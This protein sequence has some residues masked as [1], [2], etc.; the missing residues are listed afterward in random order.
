MKQDRFSFATRSLVLYALVAAFIC[1]TT[2][3]LR[4]QRGQPDLTVREHQMSELER[5][6]TRKREPTEL[7]A[8]VNEDMG[9]LKTLNQKI[10]AQ[11][12]ATDQELNYRSIVDNLAEINTRAKRLG[13]DLALPQAEKDE[14]R[15]VG[16][17]VGNGALQPALLELNKLLDSF[18]NNS[19]F[20]DTGAVDLHLAAKARADL[21]DIIGLS[22]K[23]RKSANK[24]SKAGGK[25]IKEKT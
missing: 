5:E 17:D 8:E 20:S 7:L 19:I 4:A 6:K 14:K 22:E 12:A 11:A 10:S 24:R 21:D 1:A 18:L 23:L 3:T 25:S 13:S 2:S 16:K 9:R 15:D